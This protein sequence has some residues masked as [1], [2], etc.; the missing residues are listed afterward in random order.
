MGKVRAIRLHAMAARKEIAA[1][2]DVFGKQHLDEF[3]AGQIRRPFIDFQNDVLIVGPLAFVI[4]RHTDARNSIEPTTI[5]GVVATVCLY[6]FLH[7]L[8]GSKSHGSTDFRHFAVGADVDDVVVAAEAEVSHKA[9]LFGQDLVVGQ[10]RTALKG[11]KELGGME[12]EDFATSEAADQFALVRAPESVGG[13][14][15]ELQIAIPG[16]GLQ[17][18]DVACASPSMH[19]NDSAGARRNHFLH[20]AW[21][22]IMRPR[23]DV[24]EHRGDLLPLKGVCGGNECKRRDNH[25]SRE[26]E[27]SNGDLQPYRGIT[28]R[29]AGSDTDES[30]YFGFEFLD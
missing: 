28:H 8:Q 16:D 3:V 11:I 20:L 25:F 2:Q 7:A 22:E 19:S 23:V 6:E 27:R 4:G 15:K 24:T 21:V 26:A 9:H 14:E 1:R 12:A 29:D 10:T 17:S 30:G 18:S 5:R 13:V